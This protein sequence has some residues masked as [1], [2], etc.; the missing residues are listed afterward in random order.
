[1]D[2]PYGVQAFIY[3]QW[4]SSGQKEGINLGAARPH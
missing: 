4:K 1:M 3:G 2:G